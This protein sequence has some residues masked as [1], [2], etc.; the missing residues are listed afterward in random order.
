M[1]TGLGIGGLPG[2]EA[3][4]EVGDFA[5]AG[6]AEDAGGDRAAITALAVDDDELRG[7]EFAGAVEPTGPAGCGWSFEGSGFDFAGLADV[8]NGDV[9]LLF[10]AKVGEFVCGDLRDVVE[11]VAALEPAGDAAVEVGIDVLD[12]DTGET[13]LGFA[14]LIGVFADEDDVLVETEDAR[15]PGGVLAGERDMEEP[16]TWATANSI[17]GRVSRTMAPSDCRRRTSG[18]R[19]GLGAGS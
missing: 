19:R 14:E 17:A 1:H 16:G 2:V 18:A 12:A 15:G 4:G 6:A 13:K 10:F 11:L 7:I 8:E 5:E 9:I 3:S